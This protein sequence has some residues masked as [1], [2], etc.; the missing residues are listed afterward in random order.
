DF[1]EDARRAGIPWLGLPIADIKT[2]DRALVVGSFLRKDQP[3]IAQRLRQAAK[4]GT[5]VSMLHAVDDD[6]RLPIAHRAIVP[7]SLLPLTLAE[8]VV[9]AAQGAERAVPPA[10]AGIVP[11]AQAQRSEEHTSELQS[12]DHLVC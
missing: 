6:W 2:L 5:L 1:R 3:L 10:L 9:A 8:I 4:K 12:P 11:G 7:P